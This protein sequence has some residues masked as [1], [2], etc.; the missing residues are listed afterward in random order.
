MYDNQIYDVAQG[1]SA[2][3]VTAPQ[4]AV[5][6][7]QPVTIQGTV[8]DISPGTNKLSKQPTS[9]TVFHA[10]LTQAKANGWNTYTCKSQNQ[11]TSQ[12]LQ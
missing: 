11:P 7:G 8:M 12:A 1:P 2:T 5:T 6:T 3:T 10:Y 9:Q 4:T